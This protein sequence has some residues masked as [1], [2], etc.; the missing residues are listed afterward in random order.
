MSLK[1][2]I[3]MVK[4]ELNAEEKFFENA[5]K[6]EKFFTK[7]KKLLIAL[8]VS[9]VLVVGVNTVYNYLQEGKAKAANAAL[10]V[11]EK[12]PQDTQALKT[13]QENDSK[14]YDLFNLYTAV[15]NSDQAKLKELKSSK[16]LA[17]ADLA[18]YQL[19][20]L[21]ANMK[22]LNSYAGKE[23]AL[24]KDM[25]LIQSAVLLMKE[26]KMDEAH[27]KLETISSN[28]PA[29]GLAKALMHYGIK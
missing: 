22:E 24:L 1:E 9:V 20:S 13:L 11:L 7:Y 16:A 27:R 5:I 28:S 15:N 26:N 14:L 2:N 18:A 17:V 21:D 4:E 10:L 19:A 23:D 12:N 3:S 6:A 29:Y 25:A 8:A